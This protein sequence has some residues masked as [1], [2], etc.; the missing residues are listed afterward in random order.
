MANA[1]AVEEAVE[2][3]KVSGQEFLYE[4]WA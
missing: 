4:A 3:M 1:A 2:E